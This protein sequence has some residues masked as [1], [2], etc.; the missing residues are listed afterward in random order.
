MC[1]ICKTYECKLFSS[2]TYTNQSPLALRRKIDSM[3]RTQRITQKKGLQSYDFGHQEA[4]QNCKLIGK[5]FVL[6]YSITT[7]KHHEIEPWTLKPFT[8]FKHVTNN[9]Q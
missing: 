9:L 1:K 7:T 8:A 6:P 5:S 2:M 4:G 3:Q